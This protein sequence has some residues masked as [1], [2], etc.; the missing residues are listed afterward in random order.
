MFIN[1]FL[2]SA[3]KLQENFII[4]GYSQVT[5]RDEFMFEHII[6]GLKSLS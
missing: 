1:P 2:T 4:V 5:V 6:Y 3:P